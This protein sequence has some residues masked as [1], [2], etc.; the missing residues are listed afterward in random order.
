[1][2]CRKK[3]SIIMKTSSSNRI[4]R[5]AVSKPA[6]DGLLWTTILRRLSG[7]AVDQFASWHDRAKQRRQLSELDDR[8]LADIGVTRI[9]ACQESSKPFWQA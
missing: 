5:I 9:D 2:G 6:S 3:R 4:P 8:L 7:I 1:M